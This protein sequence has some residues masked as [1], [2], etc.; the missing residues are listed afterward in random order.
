MI[1]FG[2][3]DQ[4]KLK[5]IGKIVI[6]TEHSIFNVFLVE[7]LGYNL[8]SVSQLS[9]VGYKCLFINVD[10]TVFRRSGGSLAF[11][12][13]SDGKLYLVGFTKENADLDACLLAKTDM[14]WI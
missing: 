5:G 14:G 8:L 9:H 2:D 12:G 4:G 3:G 1:N 11:K 13:V 6:T 10:V 7:S